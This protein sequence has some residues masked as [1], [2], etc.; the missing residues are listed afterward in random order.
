MCKHTL[1]SD[2]AATC[3]ASLCR[4]LSTASSNGPLGGR[5]VPLL[6]PCLCVATPVASRQSG[7]GH[8]G[9]AGPA[10]PRA[11]CPA[12]AWGQGQ[13][14]APARAAARVFPTAPQPLGKAE[15]P[16]SISPA[17]ACV[18]WPGLYQRAAVLTEAASPIFLPDGCA[19]ARPLP[20]QQARRSLYKTLAARPQCS[21]T[22]ATRRRALF[23]PPLKTN[24]AGPAVESAASGLPFSGRGQAAAR[25]GCKFF[26]PFFTDLCA[27]I[28]NFSRFSYILSINKTL[29]NVYSSEEEKTKLP[30][31]V[32]FFCLAVQDKPFLLE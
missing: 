10:V 17:A 5:P 23:W 2:R 3:V 24:R 25:L 20:Q 15:W 6:P 8:A 7:L 16:P 26:F 22:Q 32:T 30:C 31:P 14:A 21:A 12:R 18:A 27:L 29:G 9:P 13:Q 4:A 19:A 1:P 28:S 11:F